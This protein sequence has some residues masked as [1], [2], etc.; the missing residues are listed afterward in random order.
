MSLER[1]WDELQ[2]NR[3]GRIYRRRKRPKPI[4][5]KL[6]PIGTPVMPAVSKEP[7]K[8]VSLVWYRKLPACSQE[9]AGCQEGHHCGGKL[10]DCDY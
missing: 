9:C 4:Q 6:R 1:R 7:K 3:P 5:K 10:C 8:A 2:K